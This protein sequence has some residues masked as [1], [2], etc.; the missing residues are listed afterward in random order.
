MGVC[1]AAINALEVVLTDGEAKAQA[2][3]RFDRTSIDVDFTAQGD[4]YHF[5]FEI[6]GG[7]LRLG[8]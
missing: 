2:R 5:Q 3:I 7:A 6:V 1:T 4:E 8:A